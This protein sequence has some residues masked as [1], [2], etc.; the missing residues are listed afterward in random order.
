MAKE[1]TKSVREQVRA[2]LADHFEK[3][4]WFADR[5]K[6]ETGMFIEGP[7]GLGLVM[8]VDDPTLDGGLLVTLHT[9][10]M[11]ER[12]QHAPL[13]AIAE[14]S[15]EALRERHPELADV[16]LRPHVNF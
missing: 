4:R 9:D 1:D 10:D 16:P 8:V 3:H 14:E 12:S 5:V 2:F 7:V 13:L 15:F 11:I 6:R